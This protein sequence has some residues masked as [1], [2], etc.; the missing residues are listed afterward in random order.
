VSEE[1][2]I[3]SGWADLESQFKEALAPPEEAGRL[4]IT[5]LN[6]VTGEAD[7]DVFT[8]SGV[9]TPNEAKTVLLTV[10]SAT[11]EEYK[12]TFENLSLDKENKNG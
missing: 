3:E 6:L 5:G 9:A 10:Q 1:P 7:T 11:G 8:V 2:E 4:V 12:I